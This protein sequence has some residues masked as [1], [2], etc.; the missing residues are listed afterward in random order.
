MAWNRLAAPERGGYRFAGAARRDWSMRTG[1]CA[2]GPGLR[3]GRSESLDGYG[4]ESFRCARTRRVLVRGRGAA[5]LVDANG[6]LRWRAGVAVGAQ[7]VIGRSWRGIVSL[8]PYA[9]GIGS[10]ARHREAVVKSAWT[11]RPD[12]AACAGGK[13]VKSPHQPA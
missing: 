8:R 10:R 7:R 11:V 6:A 1:L 12:R 13:L 3:L 4:V 2:G 9:A 5:G